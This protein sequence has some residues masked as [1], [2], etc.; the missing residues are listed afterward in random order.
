MRTWAARR[1]RLPPEPWLSSTAA[2]L[3][4][5]TYQADSSR[6]SRDG[7]RGPPGAGSSS[8]DSWI[9]QRG[10]CV[11]ISAITN[12]ITASSG[13]ERRRRASRRRGRPP[14]ERRCGAAPAG[15]RRRRSGRRRRAAG[16]RAIVP[17]PVTSGQSGPELTT[18]RPCETTPKPSDSRP[19]TTPE[20]EPRRPRDVRLGQ[21]PGGRDGDD[22]EHA[23]QRRVGAGERQVKQ[24]E[25]D[26]REPGEQQ[27]ALEPCEAFPQPALD[28]R[29]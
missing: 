29:G 27:R 6:P 26:E 4:D 2:P 21:R 13:E 20:D 5:G 15:G 22:R 9:A 25:R 3:R 1:S 28:R 12:G 10:A 18:W 14:A 8:A 24:V 11:A 7:D 17:T 19:M 23:E 16:R